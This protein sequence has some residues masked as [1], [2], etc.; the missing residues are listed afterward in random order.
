LVKAIG[1]GAASWL[2]TMI[3]SLRGRLDFARRKSSAERGGEHID[4][5]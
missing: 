4:G 1:D 2:I 5:V 3:T